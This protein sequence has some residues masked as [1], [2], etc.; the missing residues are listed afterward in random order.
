MTALRLNALAMPRMIAVG[1]V[2]KSLPSRTSAN[3]GQDSIAELIPA[4]IGGPA[5]QAEREHAPG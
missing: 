1:P 5:W 4:E 3:S 2:W